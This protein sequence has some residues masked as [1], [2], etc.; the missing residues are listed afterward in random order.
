MQNQ[1]LGLGFLTDEFA[2]TVV[3]EVSPPLLAFVLRIRVAIM[4][5]E[6][7]MKLSCPRNP[8]LISVP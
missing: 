3:P 6:N 8:F 2:T 4:G 5:N 7:E 1:L